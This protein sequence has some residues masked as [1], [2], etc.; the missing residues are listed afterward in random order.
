MQT[1][2]SAAPRG[3]TPAQIRHAY[4]FDTLSFDGIPA[5]GRGTTIAIVTAYD[6]SNIAQDLATF[7]ATFGIPAPP[8]FRKVDQN[9]GT[10]LPAYNAAWST[11]TCIDVEWAHQ[12]APGASILLVEARSNSNADLLAAVNYARSAPGVVAVSMSWGQAEFAGETASD[13]FFTTPAGHPGVTFFAAS[14]DSGA[15][16]IYPAMSP[17]VVAV[18]GTTLSLGS[19]GSALESGWSRS[20][21]GISLFEPQPAHQAGVVT[22]SSAKR[23]TPDVALVA[24]PATGLAVCDSKAN[25]A[26]TPWV[27]YGGTSIAAPQW[28]GIAAIVAQGRAL[29]GAAALDGAK[30]FLPALYALPAADFR[31][32]VTGTS[33]GSPR[34]TAAAGYDLVTGR[35]S[36]VVGALVA[37]LVLRG[38]KL[39]AQAP[40]PAPSAPAAP[41]GFT[42]TSTGSA[43]VSLSWGAA[44]GAT[45]YS[46]YETT[47]GAATLVASYDAKTTSATISGLAPGSTHTWRLEAWNAAGKASATAQ[48]TVLATM[49][50]P[51][52][53]TIKVVSRTAVELSWSPSAG[54]SGYSIYL[55]TGRTAQRVG[56]VA[57]PATTTRITGLAPGSTLRFAVRAENGKTTASSDWI[58]VTLPG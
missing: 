38:G 54:A 57:A 24:D 47:S 37:D 16:G 55:W 53:V 44:A 32:V 3:F 36:P 4:G 5:D 39:A 56:G 26:K 23:A 6:S 12:A 51:T 49:A 11:E 2:A 18:G 50:A 31:D 14:G 42:A 30:K 28:A 13:A 46:L 35:G 45:G 41:T 58:P 40:S 52:G 17:N 9:G 1:M 22:Q 48:A 8:S 27:A 34:F 15:P 10:A 20:G 7:D 33:T 19:G 43:T 25:G 29:R 21:G